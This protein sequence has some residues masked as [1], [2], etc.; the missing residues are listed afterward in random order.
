MIVYRGF[1]TLDQASKR[2]VISIG[3][4]DG[5]HLG[6]QK[7]LKLAIQK[8]RAVGA[9]SI[10]YTFRPHPQVVLKPEV[11][12][13]LITSYDEKLR[14]FED[15]GIDCVIEEPFDKKFS[16]IDP[17]AFFKIILKRLNVHSV[18]VGYDF[19]F[20]SGRRGDLELLKTLC[21]KSGVELE[22]V[23]QESVQGEL[24]SSTRIRN[25]LFAGDVAKASRLMGRPFSYQ[26]MVIHGDG[27]GKKLGFPTANFKLENKLV[28]PFGVYAS[29]AMFEGEVYPSVT[30]IGIRPTFR[31]LPK[32]PNTGQDAA[33]A[34]IETHLFDVTLDLYGSIIDVKLIDRLRGEQKFPGVD[35]LKTQIQN[36]VSRAK[37]ILLTAKLPCH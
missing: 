16:E 23:H 1:N 30:N 27:R 35:A 14:I 9:Q 28:V 6:H 29:T 19:G 2:S 13:Q 5:V 15:L 10:V 17:D 34:L 11:P 24:A 12:V 18:I 36:D 8:A 26:G 21:P 25:F 22:V 31:D 4:F 7:I 33:S 20:G 37:E 3:N 32:G